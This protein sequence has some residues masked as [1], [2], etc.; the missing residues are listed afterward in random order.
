MDRID[1]RQ[2]LKNFTVNDWTAM[3]T[4]ERDKLHRNIFKVAYP[5]ALKKRAVTSEQIIGIGAITPESNNGE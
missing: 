5:D 2:T 3:K 4:S 1:A